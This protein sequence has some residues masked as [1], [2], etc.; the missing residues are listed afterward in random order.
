MNSQNPNEKPSSIPTGLQRYRIGRVIASTLFGKVRQGWDDLK[1]EYVIIKECAIERVRSRMTEN[2]ME[3]SEDIDKEIE[4]HWKLSQES[5][6]CDS[7]IEFREKV[8][9]SKNIYIVIEYASEGDLFGHVAKKTVELMGMWH[10]EQNVQVKHQKLQEWH[11][12]VRN[13][14][15]KILEALKFMHERNICHRDIS[16]ENFVLCKGMIVK[17]IDFGLA[18]EYEDGNFRT[19]RGAVG[20]VKYLSPECRSGHYYDGRHNDMWALGVSLWMCLIGSPPW[21]SASQSDKRYC[22][23][24]RGVGG[25]KGL[26]TRW[27]RSFMCPD[28]AVDLLSRIFRPEKDRITVDEAL[29]H[30]FITGSEFRLLSDQLYVPAPIGTWKPHK[31][32]RLEWEARRGA[33]NLKPPAVWSHMSQNLK[34]EIQSFLMRVNKQT[35]SIFDC[36]VPACME[37]KFSIKAEDVLEILIYFMA[38]SRNRVRLAEHVQRRKPLPI[39][40]FNVSEKKAQDQHEEARLKSKAAPEHEEKQELILRA[41]FKRHDQDVEVSYPLKV[42]MGAT[43]NQIKLDF[44][45]LKTKELNTP[46]LEPAELE[47]LVNGE[48]L[49]DPS[50]LREGSIISGRSHGECEGSQWFSALPQVERDMFLNNNTDENSKRKF[51]EM[52]E[53]KFQLDP[54]KCLEIW[55][56][57]SQNVEHGE[58]LENQNSDGGIAADYDWL[59]VLYTDAKG[60][61]FA[62]VLSA[63]VVSNIEDRRASISLLQQKGLTREKALQAMKYFSGK[64]GEN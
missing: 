41:S 24:R 10:A 56:Y 37:Q 36:R 31:A 49:E 3:V 29:K 11:N 64:I 53:R 26:V 59:K 47:I 45:L 27:Q 30:P 15:R 13:W 39:L 51:F 2:G 19:E 25:I 28:S 16:L 38:A 1:Q 44:A 20:K 34:E 32:L 57:F 50:M 8:Q 52:L 4:L 43:L 5:V 60:K 22:F 18:H 48:G 62:L 58:D 9:D 17:V 46:F 63:I 35:G 55:K 33:E 40:Q 23:I 6:P 42:R 14:I 21:D 54:A 12:Q 61:Y 7:I